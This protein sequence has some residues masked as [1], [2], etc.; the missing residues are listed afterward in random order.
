[1]PSW[2]ELEA[3]EPDLAAAIAARFAA[4]KHK[5]LGTVRA[6]GSPRLSGIEAEVRDGELMLA[7]MP[8]GRKFE[9]LRRDPRFALHSGSDDADPEDPGAWSGDAKLAGVAIELTDPA[10]LAHYAGQTEHMPPGE[11]ELFRLDLREAVVIRMGE[12]ADH[13][14]VDQWHHERGRT[15]VRR[16]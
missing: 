2:A 16:A 8:R 15:S 12:P 14:V 4:H 3:A 6:D 9:D 1:M 11:F 7:G 5:I 10:D 13:L